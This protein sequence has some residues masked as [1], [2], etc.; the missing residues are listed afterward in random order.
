ML[1]Q[2]DYLEMHVTNNT[3]TN[4]ITVERLYLFAMGMPM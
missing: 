4:N 3:N 1:A 2:N